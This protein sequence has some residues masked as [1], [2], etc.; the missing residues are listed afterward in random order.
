M[1]RAV[2]VAPLVETG[3]SW[4]ACFVR[5]RS[6]PSRR[7]KLTKFAGDARE[8]GHRA[9]VAIGPGREV[10]L[11][12]GRGA[13]GAGAAPD[14]SPPAATMEMKRTNPA[15]ADDHDFEAA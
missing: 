8:A 15:H 3:P 12:R 4:W 1:I 6:V 13:A 2:P 11:H 9:I 14:R 10:A 7:L 5:P